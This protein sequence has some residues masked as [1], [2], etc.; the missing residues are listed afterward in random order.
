M[1]DVNRI[2]SYFPTIAIAAL[3]LGS[4]GTTI[5]WAARHESTNV[6]FRDKLKVE[7]KKT[8]PPQILI[9]C[10]AGMELA[11]ETIDGGYIIRGKCQIVK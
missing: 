2:A 8:K 3:I 6:D 11:M 10:E 5:L 1:T 9:K 4:V 7:V